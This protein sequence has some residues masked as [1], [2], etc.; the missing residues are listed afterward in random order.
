[1]SGHTPPLHPPFSFN[2]WKTARLR[3]EQQRENW[4]WGLSL[5]G[6]CAVSGGLMG[7]VMLMPERA[8]PVQDAPPAAIA[9]DLAPTPVSI[10]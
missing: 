3:K 10:P 9:M 5:L 6:V 8:P 2:H 7:W 1:M 4:L